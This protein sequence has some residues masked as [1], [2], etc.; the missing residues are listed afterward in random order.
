MNNHYVLA[1]KIAEQMENTSLTTGL[2]EM[3]EQRTQANDK[4]VGLQNKMEQANRN[5]FLLQKQDDLSKPEI[6]KLS[7]ERNTQSKVHDEAK[8]V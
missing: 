2:Q 4:M 8:R 5:L 7:I 1:S 6:G 3:E